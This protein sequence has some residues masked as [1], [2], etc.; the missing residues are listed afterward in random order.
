MDILVPSLFIIKLMTVYEF[1]FYQKTKKKE[2]VTILG[3]IYFQRPYCVTLSQ[4]LF[5]PSHLHKLLPE[6]SQYK[7]RMYS[8]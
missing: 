8:L 3:F 6:G 4:D 7:Q 1:K 5:Q 2:H